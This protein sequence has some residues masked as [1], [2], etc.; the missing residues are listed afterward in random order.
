MNTFPT[1]GCGLR[2]QFV[3]LPFAGILAAV[4]FLA[5]VLPTPVEAQAHRGFGGPRFGVGLGIGF[6][7]GVLG[8]LA[9]GNA[10]AASP[11]YVYSDPPPVYYYQPAP[12]YV[13]VPAPPV[14]VVVAAPPA[15]AAPAASPAPVAL[16]AGKT[17]RIVYDSNGK[18]VGV[19]VS[20]ADGSQEF[21]PLTQ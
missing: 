16:A 6:G 15:P 18:P 21:V 14:P 2:R 10:Y 11:M 3:S 8:G 4:V 19:I 1:N 17:G 7:L 20:N 5:G 9:V 12:Q 13:Y